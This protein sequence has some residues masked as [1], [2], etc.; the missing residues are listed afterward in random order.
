M[1]GRREEG[2]GRGGGRDERI[3]EGSE[4]RR[5]MASEE[6]SRNIASGSRRDAVLGRWR[7]KEVKWEVM[8]RERSMMGGFSYKTYS[9]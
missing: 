2:G 6:G 1:E 9:L 7:V 8:G 5:W 4:R 3:R